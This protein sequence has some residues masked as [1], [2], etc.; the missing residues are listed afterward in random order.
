[1]SHAATWAIVPVKSLEQAKQRLAAVLPLAVRRRLMLVMLE[2][3]LAPALY[4][5]ARDLITS[6]DWGLCWP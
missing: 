4:P 6:N 2:D 3:V 1:M 5:Q